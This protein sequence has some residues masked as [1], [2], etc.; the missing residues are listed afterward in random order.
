VG[1]I[2]HFPIHIA[3]RVWELVFGMA[4]WRSS[5]IVKL[6]RCKPSD[7]RVARNEDAVNFCERFLNVHVGESKGGNYAIES[8]ILEWQTFT[9]ALQISSV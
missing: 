7:K 9:G 5:A 2:T 1:T 6:G 8:L 3:E 4:L